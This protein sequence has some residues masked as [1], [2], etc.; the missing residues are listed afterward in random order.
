M[1]E[2]QQQAVKSNLSPV[3]QEVMP[4]M[5]KITEI[6]RRRD[7]ISLANKLVR[8]EMQKEILN[9]QDKA[10]FDTVVEDVRTQMMKDLEKDEN[11]QR[12]VLNYLD[13]IQGIV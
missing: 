5:E 3:A 11:G 2:I 4:Y 12:I 7:L 6:L 10:D 9:E 8:Q 13:G 1:T